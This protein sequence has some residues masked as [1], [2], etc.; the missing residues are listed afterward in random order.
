M[1]PPEPEPQRTVQDDELGICPV[2]GKPVYD[3]NIGKTEGGKPYH[4]GCY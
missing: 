3:S 1:K 4:K 2:C